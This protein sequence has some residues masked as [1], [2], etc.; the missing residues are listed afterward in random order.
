MSFPPTEGKRREGPQLALRKPSAP[1][2]YPQ[3]QH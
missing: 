1:G 2:F 3:K